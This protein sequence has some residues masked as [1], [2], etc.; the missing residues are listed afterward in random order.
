MEH[1][2]IQEYITTKTTDSQLTRDIIS[3][4]KEG[5]NV[6][7]NLVEQLTPSANSLRSLLLLAGEISKRDKVTVSSVFDK[8][9]YQSIICP[10]GN[11]S[12]SQRLSKLR[13]FLEDIRYPEKAKLNKKL[14]YLRTQLIRKYG[15]SIELPKDLEG[16]AIT[17]KLQPKSPKDLMQYSTRLSEMSS[18]LELKD[19]YNTLL[20]DY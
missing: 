20:G 13:G 9:D 1:N 6:A 2:I 11:G 17:I 12:A 16:N 18:S 10:R 4:Q 19:L 8:V 5:T 7:E 15:L 14:E 3:L